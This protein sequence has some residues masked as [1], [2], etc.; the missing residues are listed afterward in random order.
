MFL[1]VI[2]RFD[3]R[4]YSLP[5]R[6]PLRTA[7]GPWT[8][9]E[10]ILV[11]LEDEGGREGFGE[12]A[13]IPW[14]GTETVAEAAELCAK[15]GDKVSAESLATLAPQFGCVRFALAMA[16]SEI[17]WAGG[18]HPAGS[19]KSGEGTRPTGGAPQEAGSPRV[20]LTALLPA[21]RAA[22][23]VLRD[24]LESGW[25]CFKWKVGVEPADLELGLLD[26]L[27]AELPPYARLR[28]DANGAWDRRLAARWLQRCADRP[29]EFVEQPVTPTDKSALFGLAADFPV[30]LAL[31]ESVVR[32]DEARRWQAEGWP[33]V[34]VIKPALAGPLDELAAWAAET[35]ADVV[36]S[37]AIE[38]A[39]AR[40][41]I[42]RHALAH[43][44]LVRRAPGFGVGDVFGD[45]RHDGPATGPVLDQSWADSINPADNWRSLPC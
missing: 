16:Q 32:L 7:H 37:S 44:A 15:F 34:F 36:L 10:V 13:P 22:L 9:R 25:L 8:V 39:V 17:R 30:K 40:R 14:F 27:L 24:R 11:R 29:L 43:P 31:D 12:M 23:D 45:R 33:G 41:A 18:P 2:F 21:G 6:T 26:E 19:P 3:Y 4:L 28:L 5:L 42:V 35:R 1:P 38:T 20:P